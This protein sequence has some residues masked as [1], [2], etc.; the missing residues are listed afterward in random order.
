MKDIDNTL[1]TIIFIT[2]V[3]GIL[4]LFWAILFE[5]NQI[6][7][8]IQTEVNIEKGIQIS[9]EFRYLKDFADR[10]IKAYGIITSSLVTIVIFLFS[11]VGYN[12]FTFAVKKLESDFI[13][14]MDNRDRM[15]KAE[16]SKQKHNISSLG[17]SVGEVLLRFA[18]T[19]YENNKLDYL[20]INTLNQQTLNSIFDNTAL[21]GE[22]IESLEHSQRNLESKINTLESNQQSIISKLNQ[23]FT[24]IP[25]SFNW[26]RYL[27]KLS[28]F[29]IIS[30][31]ISFVSILNSLTF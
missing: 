17:A 19:F 14:R 28:L 12:I 5:V 22:E 18:D 26:V 23:I 13:L 1:L 9:N 11:F 31:F 7:D 27:T 15:H 30:F 16:I 29:F 6:N 10:N 2:I 3:A 20:I 4:A 25:F 24:I 21:L 8:V